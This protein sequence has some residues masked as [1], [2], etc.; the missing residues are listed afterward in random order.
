M[1]KREENSK[2]RTVK[3]GKILDLG[4]FQNVL[5]ESLANQHR[6]H[7]ADGLWEG[8]LEEKTP[9]KTDGRRLGM[10]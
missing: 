10:I 5:N 2:I 6:R 1:G 9:D 7:L 3:G 4:G 8:D